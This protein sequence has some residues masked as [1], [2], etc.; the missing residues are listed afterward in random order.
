[1]SVGTVVH[2]NVSSRHHFRGRK[3]NFAPF[4]YTFCPAWIKFG[5]KDLHLTPISNQRGESQFTD[6][7]Q[8]MT[9]AF[10]DIRWALHTA[11]EYL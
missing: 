10:S 3:G 8:L 9:A 5:T 11:V 1:M 2:T 6:S 4:F 7:Q